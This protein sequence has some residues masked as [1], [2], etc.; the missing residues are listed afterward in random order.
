LNFN[1]FPAANYLVSN[2]N[3][4][5]GLCI[6]EDMHLGHSRK[7][8]GIF[9]MNL[10]DPVLCGDMHITYRKIGFE[11]QT[12]NYISWVHRSVQLLYAPDADVE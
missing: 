11:Q 6:A 9:D 4:I 10:L 2:G 3:I 12:V 1:I 5:R 7:G 8:I